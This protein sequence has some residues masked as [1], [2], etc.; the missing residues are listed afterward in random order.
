MIEPTVYV[1]GLTLLQD[2]F[3][4]ELSEPVSKALYKALS[5]RMDGDGFSMACQVI[6]ES[7]KP[8]PFNFPAVNDFVE[9]ARGAIEEKATQEWMV[10]SDF[11]SRANL[12]QLSEIGKQAL[13][14]IGGR[15]DLGYLPIDQMP[16]RKKEFIKEYVSI[17]SE[18]RRQA[19]LSL[20]AQQRGLHALN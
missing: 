6:F 13:Q 15:N 10:A 9:A 18:L 5:N 14:R 3:G 12:S 16:F 2:W 1:Q 4:K 20:P 11:T 19:V 17:D 8:S 7:T